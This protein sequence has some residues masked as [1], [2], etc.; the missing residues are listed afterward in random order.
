MQLTLLRWC[1]TL[2]VKTEGITPSLKRVVCPVLSKSSDL[3]WQLQTTERSLG[4]KFLLL[5]AAVQARLL[6]LSF[7]NLY[8]KNVCVTASH[9]SVISQQTLPTNKNKPNA[10]IIKTTFTHCFN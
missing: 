6:T 4:T 7:G 9:S 1:V 10:F 8:G 2:N 3:K 5:R